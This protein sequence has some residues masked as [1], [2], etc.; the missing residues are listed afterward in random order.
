MNE[1]MSK[2]P[3]PCVNEEFCNKAAQCVSH[4]ICFIFHNEFIWPIVFWWMNPRVPTRKPLFVSESMTPWHAFLEAGGLVP[5]RIPASTEKTAF[6]G[7]YISPYYVPHLLSM[8][9]LVWKPCWPGNNSDI[10]DS[11]FFCEWIHSSWLFCTT[12]ESR[13]L[14][15]RTEGDPVSDGV[16]PG[17]SVSVQY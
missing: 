4:L 8:C 3:S 1:W 14:D 15:W 2:L 7:G 10:N 12:M 17:D 16:L 13:D 9:P 5:A 6:L 11:L